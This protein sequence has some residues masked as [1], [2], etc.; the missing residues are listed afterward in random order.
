MNNK[1]AFT[2]GAL[3]PLL[4][5]IGVVAAGVL[6]LARKLKGEFPNYEKIM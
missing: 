4:I 5:L 1:L 6:S 2:L 3:S